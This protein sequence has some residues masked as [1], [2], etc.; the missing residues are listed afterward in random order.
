F[1]KHL[2]CHLEVLR[3]VMQICGWT[4]SGFGCA[5]FC[6]FEG[7][8]HRHK[9]SLEELLRRFALRYQP[10]CRNNKQR[11]SGRRGIVPRPTPPSGCFIPVLPHFLLH[12]F[13][14]KEVTTQA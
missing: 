5:S 8:Y 13:E 2:S 14:V 7:I 3:I 4:L 6:R 9:V 10:N 11:K 12:F 1:S